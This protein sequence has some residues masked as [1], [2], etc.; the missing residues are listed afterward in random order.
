[1]VNPTLLTEVEAALGLANLAPHV[2][3]GQK[4]VAFADGLAGR[5]VVKVIEL[6]PPYAA[7]ALER[8]HREVAVLT[9]IIHPN[10]VRLESGLVEIGSPVRA[11]CWREEYLDGTDLDGFIATLGDWTS[12]AEMASGVLAALSAF[13]A[14][15]AV[16]RDLSPRNVRRTADGT[17]KL[18]DPGVARLLAETTI[19]GPMDPGTP[20]YMS[21]EHVSPVARPI[22]ASDVFGVGILLHQALTGT[23]PVPFTGDRADYTRRLLTVSAPPLRTIRPDLAPD[24]ARFVDTCLQ[25]QAGR[26]YLDATEALAALGAL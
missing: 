21:P 13:H 11:V 14:T 6:A 2:T 4:T 24:R 10:V 1:M 19:T 7:L 22:F 3:G 18:M 17:Y 26:R 20:G 16:H 9:A 12:A 5:T 15:N 25:R 8:A 23:V